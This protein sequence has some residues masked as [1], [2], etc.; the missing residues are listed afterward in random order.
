[1]FEHAK[2][3]S[4]YGSITFNQYG[5]ENPAGGMN[6]AG[7]VVEQLWL[8]ETEYPKADAR[9]ALGTQEW[10]QYLLDT[11]GTTNEAVKNGGA[12]RIESEV[13]VQYLISD[14]AGNAATLE[15]I[16]GQL[17]VYTGANLPIPALTS[18]T[19]DDSREFASHADVTKTTTNDS[20][21][22]FVRATK[23]IEEFEK[24]PLTGEQAITYAFV[25]LSDAA[26]K[27]PTKDPSQWTAVY[28]QK[29][30]RIY[31]RTLQSQQIKWVDMKAFAYACGT[32]VKIFDV[33][34][35]K[36]VM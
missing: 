18:N 32:V 29:R 16:K 33:N 31:F 19:Y 4:K 14:K 34:S 24:R 5:R 36:R 15:F 8:D 12:V 3:I 13:K 23:E 22:R 30:R 17:I 27:N 28:D 26:Q 20:F 7:L 11:S 1:L 9:P 2:W 35:R 21:D 10:V 25:V 6:E